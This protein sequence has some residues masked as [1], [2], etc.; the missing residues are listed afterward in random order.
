MTKYPLRTVLKVRNRFG[1]MHGEGEGR[2]TYSVR[3]IASYFLSLHRPNQRWEI[4][5]LKLQKLVF[6]AQAYS[7]VSQNGLPLFKDDFEAWEHGPVCRSLYYGYV[8]YGYNEI[9][10]I[11]RSLDPVVVD[12]LDKVWRH[13]GSKSAK[14]LEQMTT[15]ESP[16]IEARRRGDARRRTNEKI[17]KDEMLTYYRTCVCLL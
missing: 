16:W 11:S 4:S 5:H 15:N 7:L 17:S 1:R 2:S 13:Y 8:Q 12:M 6:Y 3:D 10:Q 9:P 14:E